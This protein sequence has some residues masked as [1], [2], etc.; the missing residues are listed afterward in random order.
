M[1]FVTPTPVLSAAM[2]SMLSGAVRVHP[3]EYCVISERTAAELAE[4]LEKVFGP[5]VICSVPR[6]DPD[7]VEGILKSG[8]TTMRF[9]FCVHPLPW[10]CYQALE[11]E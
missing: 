3:A 9:T 11:Q 6:Q 5:L 8:Q 10:Y 7:K 1:D 4:Y 2:M